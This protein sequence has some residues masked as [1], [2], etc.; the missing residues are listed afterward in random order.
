MHPPPQPGHTGKEANLAINQA[1]TQDIMEE[2]KIMSGEAI[3]PMPQNPNPM[4]DEG[5]L[6]LPSLN[7]G[8]SLNRNEFP[9]S[10]LKQDSIC[11]NYAAEDLLALNSGGMSRQQS[12]MGMFG[13]PTSSHPEENKQAEPIGFFSPG[14]LG[15]QSSVSSN[16]GEGKT[17]TKTAENKTDPK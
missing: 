7:R 14:M 6:M 17:E 1:T 5:P 11:S 3:P 9:L 13:K 16:N 4:D 10:L 15:G 8:D 12:V 2:P